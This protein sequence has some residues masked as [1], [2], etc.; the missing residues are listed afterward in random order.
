VANADI[1]FRYT[2]RRRIQGTGT[3]PGTLNAMAND[4]AGLRTRL[5]AINSTSYSTAR[6]DLMTKNDMEYAVRLADN[7]AG[8]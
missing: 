4:V 6:L 5:T 2:D 8:L 3:K 7:A 1:E